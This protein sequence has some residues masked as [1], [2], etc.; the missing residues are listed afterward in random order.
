MKFLVAGVLLLA[1][2]AYWL[3]TPD[4]DLAWLEARYL[5]APGDMM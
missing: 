4:R 5:D 1:V 3:W 2:L